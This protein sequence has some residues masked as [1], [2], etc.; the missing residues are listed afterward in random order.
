[1]L[2]DRRKNGDLGRLAQRYA[3]DQWLKGLSVARYSPG[4]IVHP[5]FRGSAVS[6]GKVRPGIRLP[7][8][9]G[10]SARPPSLGSAKYPFRHQQITTGAEKIT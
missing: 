7:C 8:P 3:D 5:R 2:V 6:P 4:R 1:M 10:R 9:R